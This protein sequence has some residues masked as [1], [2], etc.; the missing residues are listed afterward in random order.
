MGL[1]ISINVRIDDRYFAELNSIKSAGKY[2]EYQ[3][4]IFVCSKSQPILDCFDSAKPD[5]ALEFDLV[6]EGIPTKMDIV[7]FS[8]EQTLRNA[9]VGLLRT[10]GATKFTVISDG[11]VA[12]HKPRH[13]PPLPSKEQAIKAHRNAMLEIARANEA[14]KHAEALAAIARREATMP[15]TKQKK[16]T[17]DVLSAPVTAKPHPKRPNHAPNRKKLNAEPTLSV[18]GQ[19]PKEVTITYKERRKPPQQNKPKNGVRQPVEAREKSSLQSALNNASSHTQT[20]AMTLAFRFAH[21]R[22]GK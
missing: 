12:E 22:G 14:K 7:L 18:V 2:F 9:S 3:I 19:G 21:S 16:P 6:Q 20:T 15:P 11:E 8:S 13:R 17:T 4:K 5:V 10:L 1:P